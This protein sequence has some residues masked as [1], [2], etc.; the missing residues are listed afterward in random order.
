MNKYIDMHCHILPEVDDG[1]NSLE[2]TKE[3]LLK[4]YNEG[5]RYIIATPHCHPKRGIASRAELKKQLELVRQEAKLLDEKM[6]IFIGHEIYYGQDVP[7][8]L[9][10]KKILT[11]NGREYILVEFPPQAEESYI[12]QGVMRLQARGYKVILAHA[13]RY[14]AVREHMDFVEHLCQMGTLLQVNADSILGAHGRG[15]KK[16]VRELLEAEL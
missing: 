3:M 6:M 15:V 12:K 1:A 16:F 13:E 5:I 11:M 7:E 2:E 8:L 9:S 10:Q 4:A 14:E